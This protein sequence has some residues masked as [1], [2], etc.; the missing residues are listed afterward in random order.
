MSK[1]KTIKFS[2]S[3]ICER[4]ENNTKILKITPNGRKQRQPMNYDHFQAQKEI[5]SNGGPW[6][7]TN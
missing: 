6:L 5:D 2:G 3:S 7:I 1:N 4:L